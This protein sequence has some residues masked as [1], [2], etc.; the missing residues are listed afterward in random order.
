MIRKVI[1]AII[2]ALT[3]FFVVHNYNELVIIINTLRRAEAGW[4]LVAVAAQLLWIVAIAG[5]LQST[6]HLTGMRETLRRMIALT[7]AGNFI[8]VVA[9]SYGAGAMAVFIADGQNRGKPAGKITTASFLYLVYDYLGL[10][11][12]MTIGFILLKLRGLLGTAIIGAGIFVSTIG[13]ALT[14]ATVVGIYSSDRLDRLIVWLVHAINRL[15]QPIIKK[16]LIDL[17]G[18]RGFGVDLASGLKE[19]R[20]SP[21]NLIKPIG[22]ALTR[23]TMMMVILYFVSR[24]YANPFDLATVIMSF[25]VSYLFTIASVTP[26]GV[27]FVEGAMS[28]IQVSMGIDPAKSVA[29]AVAYRGF[30]FWLILFYGFFAIRAIDYKYNSSDR[31]ENPD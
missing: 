23:K 11:I 25:T 10:M 7:A 28:L 31:S 3:I 12:I 1:Y 24:A 21:G 18:A 9:P 16:Q 6:Y 14:V 4:L 30:T 17:D 2:F 27:G 22:W 8:N 29:I 15:L 26:S 13:V 20:R 19:I 5:N